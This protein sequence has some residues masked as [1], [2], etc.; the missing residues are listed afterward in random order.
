V[1]VGLS[2]PVSDPDLKFHYKSQTIK[3]NCT[4]L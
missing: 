2:E 4:K 1:S 3:H